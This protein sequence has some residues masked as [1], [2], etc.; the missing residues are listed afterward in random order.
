ML[1][2]PI[3]VVKVEPYNP[4]WRTWFEQEKEKFQI[5]LNLSLAFVNPKDFGRGN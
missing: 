4:H 1:G 2:L 5:I 3:G